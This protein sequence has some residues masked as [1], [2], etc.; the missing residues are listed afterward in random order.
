MK[1][2]NLNEEEMKYFVSMIQDIIDNIS[3]DTVIVVPDIWED[4]ECCTS[5]TRVYQVNRLTDYRYRVDGSYEH[6]ETITVVESGKYSAFEFVGFDY[7][8]IKIVVKYDTIKGGAFDGYRS[9]FRVEKVT[10]GINT[11]MEDIRRNLF[12]FPFKQK[13]T[14]R[15]KL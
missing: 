10:C 11:S 2:L 15:L 8:P 7:D 4:E 9:G 14:K 5:K 3:F 12:L 6:N 1:T 13:N